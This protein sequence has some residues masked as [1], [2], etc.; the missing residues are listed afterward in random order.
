[1]HLEPRRLSFAKQEL[2]GKGPGHGSLANALLTD[3]AKSMGQPA[4][5]LLRSQDAN[6]TLMTGDRGK[7]ANGRSRCPTC[8]G[9]WHCLATLTSLS[10]TRVSCD[11]YAVG[12]SDSE[13]VNLADIVV[14]RQSRRSSRHSS[15][16]MD[17]EDTEK[18]NKIRELQAVVAK[19]L[20]GINECRFQT[21][22]EFAHECPGTC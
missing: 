3:E 11:S 12:V 5:R 7:S 13:A 19:G 1:V 6:G 14:R 18:Q 17:A 16:L 20:K 9:C 10:L 8:S 21:D 15:T 4:A 2:F 22:C